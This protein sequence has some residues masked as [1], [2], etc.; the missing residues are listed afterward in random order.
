MQRRTVAAAL[1]ALSLSAIIPAA[2]AAA[3]LKVGATAGPHAA[4]VAAAARVA[5]ASGL[6]VKVIEFTD[7]LSPNRALEEGALDVV[8]YQHEPFLN[9]FN[10]QQG[11]HLAKIGN[12]VVQPM[13]LY[14]NRI[15][16]LASIPV[17][18]RIAI[19]NDP[20]NSGRA[21]LLLQNAGLIKLRDGVDGNKAL[22]VDIR[23]N[24]KNLRIVELEAAQLPRSL[25]DVD[26]A[27]IPMNY[28]ISAGLSPK[29]QGFFFEDLKA[30]FALMIIASRENNRNDRNVQAFVRAYQSEPVRAFILK[31]F[32]GAVNPAW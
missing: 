1:A 28:V 26:I 7:Y 10:R 25:D 23:K 22:V 5:E 16:K 4:I 8:V 29:K 27:A 32:D 12:A 31:T 6:K 3:T 14:S 15:R 19:P 2:H 18:A 11:T 21:L 13:G 17:G 9:N 20:T 30:P 24:P